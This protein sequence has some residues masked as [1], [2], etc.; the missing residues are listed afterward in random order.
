MRSENEESGRKEELNM[1][2]LK[3][4]FGNKGFTVTG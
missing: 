2:A 3:G 1:T 4:G